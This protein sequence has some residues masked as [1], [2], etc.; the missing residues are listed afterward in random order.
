MIIKQ[1]HRPVALGMQG[2]LTRC[3]YAAASDWLATA[4]IRSL[5]SQGHGSKQ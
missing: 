1:D 3:L 2:A 5:R 4:C